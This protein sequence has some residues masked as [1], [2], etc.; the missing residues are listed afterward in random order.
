MSKKDL[1]EDSLEIFRERESCIEDKDKKVECFSH[2]YPM[3][4][5]HA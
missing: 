2:F 3:W 5:F 4:H 1:E